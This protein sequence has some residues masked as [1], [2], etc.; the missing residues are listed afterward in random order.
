MKNLISILILFLPLITL[1][2]SYIVNEYEP[3]TDSLLIYFDTDTSSKNYYQRIP[4]CEIACD[5]VIITSTVNTISPLINPCSQKEKIISGNCLNKGSIIYSFNQYSGKL[6]GYY[7][8]KYPSK[9]TWIRYVFKKN[10]IIELVQHYYDSYSSKPLIKDVNRNLMALVELDEE[11]RLK[12]IKAQYDLK[13]KKLKKG[14]FK[15][16]SGTI[17]FYRADGTLLR[18]IE[19]QYGLPD[20]QC[21]YYY[22]TG[23]ILASGEF[24]VGMITGVWKEFSILRKVVATT[25]FN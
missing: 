25:D 16:G 14:N 17:L 19:M 23:Q 8:L 2:Q 10:K 1:S 22:P 7:V 3:K 4:S 12:N 5:D 21:I 24:K 9:E 18:S 15:D 13:G 20:G 6:E 11:G